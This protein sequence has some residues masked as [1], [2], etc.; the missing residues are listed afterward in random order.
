MP[1]NLAVSISISDFLFRSKWL[2]LYLQALF[3]P[4]W[5]R[6]TEA[7]W[8]SFVLHWYL[9]QLTMRLVEDVSFEITMRSN[10]C[11]DAIISRKVALFFENIK[12]KGDRP[13]AL[14]NIKYRSKFRLHYGWDDWGEAVGF[15][16]G[17][18]RLA[19]GHLGQGVY[20]GLLWHF[21]FP[22]T[23]C[24]VPWLRFL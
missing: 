3:H 2:A 16:Q 4:H 17:A 18:P 10:K 12:K 6:A 8:I 5:G 1:H 11:R 24:I 21:V 19:D 9:T 23:S 22:R 14:V 7:S 20:L 15:L 13:A